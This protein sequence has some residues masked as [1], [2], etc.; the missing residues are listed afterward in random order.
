M[1][2]LSVNHLIG[3]KYITKQDIDLIFEMAD[4][5]KRSYQSSYQKKVPFF[6]RCYHCQYFL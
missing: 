5:F 4:H 2:E 6:T 3:I 1:K